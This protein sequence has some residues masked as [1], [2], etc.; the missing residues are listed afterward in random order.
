MSEVQT[1]PTKL[2]EG[3]RA[4]ADWPY[5]GGSKIC[6]ADIRFHCDPGLLESGTA[7]VLKQE[8]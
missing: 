2:E 1:K 5:N 8:A 3:G 7:D 6:E 4:S